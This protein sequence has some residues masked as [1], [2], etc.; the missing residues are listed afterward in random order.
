VLVWHSSIAVCAAGGF[1]AAT[2]FESADQ[3]F[4]ATGHIKTTLAEVI[5]TPRARLHRSVLLE[6]MGTNVFKYTKK[7][8]EKNICDDTKA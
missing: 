8:G 4:K 1:G 2:A 7:T 3:H 6:F 5:Q